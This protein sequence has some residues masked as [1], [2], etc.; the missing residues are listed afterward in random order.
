M[1]AEAGG[2]VG[3]VD[4]GNDAV[5][6]RDECVEAVEC[7]AGFSEEGSA[8]NDDAAAHWKYKPL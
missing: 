4:G 7:T 8:G 5:G 1:V 2:E 3:Q 6:L